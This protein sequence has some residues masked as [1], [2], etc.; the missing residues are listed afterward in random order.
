MYKYFTTST[1]SG[2]GL[3]M[4]HV[5]MQDLT[6]NTP[7]RAGAAGIAASG[8]INVSRGVQFLGQGRFASSIG[9]FPRNLL[10]PPR[11]T[12]PITISNTA[13][14]IRTFP[15]TFLQPNTTGAVQLF[16]MNAAFGAVA[17]NDLLL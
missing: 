17:N 12:I 3:A 4:P 2:S 16:L 13:G 1:G 15:G 7:T 14:F 11:S 5:L 6:L 10:V 8:S 9:P